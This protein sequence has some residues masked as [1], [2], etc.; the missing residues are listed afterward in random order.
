MKYEKTSLFHHGK[1]IWIVL[2]QNS[3]FT[4]I[5]CTKL[6][7]TDM[8]RICC[9]R[10]RI[11]VSTTAGNVWEFSTNIVTEHWKIS[12]DESKH[13][14]HK[15]HR[16]KQQT[17]HGIFSDS[18]YAIARYMPSPVRLS[19][20][21]SVSLCPSVT[22]VDQSKT[23]EVR[24]MQPLPQ[25]SPM[26]VSWRLTWPWNSKGKIGSRVPND[27]GRKNTQFSANKSPYLG[28]GAR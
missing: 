6:H 2:H 24:I 13:S 1:Q 17:N 3:D 28:N 12:L 20:C 9:I 8:L 4:I 10:T 27:R 16:R 26:T 15:L 19:V 5:K 7:F 18:I 23:V 11:I 21:L 25:S 14:K 22:R